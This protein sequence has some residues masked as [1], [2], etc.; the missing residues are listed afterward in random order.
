MDLGLCNSHAYPYYLSN[1][2][3][4]VT[5]I[6]LGLVLVS[7]PCCQEAGAVEVSMLNIHKSQLIP[8]L[9]RGDVKIDIRSPQ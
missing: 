9:C 2:I 8:V 7:L 6:L 4:V 1:V 3:V 5:I